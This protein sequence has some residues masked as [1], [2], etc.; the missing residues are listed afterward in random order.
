MPWCNAG[1]GRG[2]GW[3]MAAQ[4]EWD[5]WSRVCFS[6]GWDAV[7][8][9]P[10]NNCGLNLDAT[11][12]MK[13]QPLDSVIWFRCTTHLFVVSPQS[14]SPRNVLHLYPCLSS[15]VLFSTSALSS[16]LFLSL[17]ASNSSV[18]HTVFVAHMFLVLLMIK[19]HEKLF[20]ISLEVF[21]MGD[22]K[23]WRGIIYSNSSDFNYELFCSVH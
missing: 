3:L 5:P 13:T 14:P 19:K 2:P 7:S 12:R 15:S 1:R 18:T 23:L 6:C 21:F 10:G 20:E 8:P 16:L 17:F 11:S 9:E 22:A 4:S